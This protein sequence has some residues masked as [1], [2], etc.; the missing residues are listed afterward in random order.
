MRLQTFAVISMLCV[1][2]AAGAEK[3]HSPV[4]TTEARCELFFSPKGG[5]T[6]EIVQ[7]I[8]G[9]KKSILV[10]AYSFTSDPIA[11]AL[12]EAKLRGVDVKAVI[13]SARIAERSSNAYTM[14]ESGV[15]VYSDSQHAIQHQK[16]IVIDPGEATSTVIM[17][18]FNF[19]GNA[20]NNNSENILVIKNK[21]LAVSFATNWETHKEHSRRCSLSERGPE[22]TDYY[23]ILSLALA[24]LILLYTLNSLRRKYISRRK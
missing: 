12:A 19:T 2:M 5:C 7:E 10:L 20:E 3:K 8:A 18:S 15:E 13:D 9:A 4:C 11:K 17:G 23:K 14:M 16:V 1:S 22:P 24:G 6:E 21:E